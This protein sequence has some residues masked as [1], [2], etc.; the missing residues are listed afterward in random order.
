[1]EMNWLQKNGG[2]IIWFI[3]GLIIGLGIAFDSCYWSWS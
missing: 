3:F 1:M 2:Y